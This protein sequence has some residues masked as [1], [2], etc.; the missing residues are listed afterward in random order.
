MAKD[1]EITVV[2]ESFGEVTSLSGIP[3]LVEIYGED[4]GRRTTLDRPD[5]VIGRS[6]SCNIQI[7]QESV[8]RQHCRIVT[9]GGDSKLY[10]LGSTNGTYVNDRRIDEIHLRDGDLVRVGRSIFKYLAG[11]NLE[12]KYH[13]EIY[14]LTTVDGLTQCYNKRY[15]LDSL[16][17]ELNRSQRYARKM[18]LAMFDIDHF[19]RINDTFGHLAGDDVLRE[20]A[21]LVARNLRREDIFARYGGEEFA[22][23]LPETDTSGARQM[24]EK[25]R[26]LIEEHVFDFGDVVIPVTISLGIKTVYVNDLPISATNFIA[27]ADAKLYEAKQGGRNRVC[28]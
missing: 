4:I 9:H 15:F 22:I 23:V 11:S 19:K 12:A 8:S 1:T 16:E 13:E 10:D 20:L 26:G 25:L 7:D 28:A 18:S 24:C 17:R 27:G 21:H 3:C 6:E 5:L 14:R 2:T